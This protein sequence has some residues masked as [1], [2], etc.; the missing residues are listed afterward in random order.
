[1]KDSAIGRMLQD[2]FANL[3]AQLFAYAEK[4]QED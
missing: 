2:V 4:G 3:S 1:M